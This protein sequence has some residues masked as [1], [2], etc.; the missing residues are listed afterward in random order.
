MEKDNELLEIISE[1]NQVLEK[2]DYRKSRYISDVSWFKECAKMIEKN[3][4]RVAIMGITSSGK[5]TLVNAILGENI[6]PV[7]I[8]PS[9]S[10]IIT[11]SKGEKRQATVYFHHKECEILSGE[12]LNP[13][14]IRYFADESVNPDN[15]LKV[16]QIDITVPDFLLGDNI[17]IIDSPGLDAC[18]L[19]MH[20]K[21]TLEILLPT[22]D[23]CVFLTTVKSNSDAVNLEKLKTVHEKGKQIIMVQNMID[24]VESKIGKNGIIEED[25]PT[26]LKKHKK[27]AERLLSLGTDNTDEF[28]VIQISALNGFKG[29]VN[30]DENLYNESNLSSF[31][32]GIE[33]CIDK[34]MPDI[35]IAR[36]ISIKK[37]ID[38]I[39]TTDRG[40]ISG[41]EVQH[42]KSL[43]KV[44]A[45]HIDDLVLDFTNARDKIAAKIKLI[46][47]VVEN[48]IKSINSGNESDP[49]GYLSII[50]LINTQNEKLENRILGIV[51]RCEENK[52]EIYRRLNLDVRFSYSIPSMITGTIDVKHKYEERKRK[53]EKKGVF[54]LGKRVL[55]QMF[56]KTWGYDEV[57]Y[58]KEIV[59]KDATIAMVEE[60][61]YQ[62][63][64]KYLDILWEWSNQY[65]KS[66]NLFYS[67]VGKRT[68]EYESKKE[69]KIQ[70]NDITDVIRSL[71]YMSNKLS[72]RRLKRKDE[73][74]Y[75][76]L[77]K[78]GLEDFEFVDGTD[79]SSEE[80]ISDK[81]EAKKY[82][83]MNL[84]E[85]ENSHEKHS[86]YEISNIQYN[87]YKLSNELLERNYLLV[88][89]YI[90]KKSICT[91]SGN[92]KT[93]F[94]TY[95]IDFCVSFI[96]RIC[97]IYLNENQCVELKKNGI[98][99]QDEIVIIYELAENNL[100]AYAAFEKLK[101]YNN[102]LFIIFNGIQIGN[103]QKQILESRMIREFMTNNNV[104]INLVVDSSREFINAD[105][106]KELLV[107]VFNLK[108]HLRNK[109]ISSKQGYILINSRNPI[110]NMALIEAQERETLIL[111][112]YLNLKENLFRNAFSRSTQER[113]V[114]EEILDY[115]LD[116]FI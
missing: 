104:F 93:I 49:D 86:N 46:D 99:E 82:I 28:E 75:E 26:I 18:N 41:S 69:Q 27:R 66:L 11:C 114:I 14:K 33:N 6:L 30:K 8:K 2:D 98:Y 40:I 96:S 115:F 103:S 57:E 90:N 54:N 45:T 22:I 19:E 38:Q 31:V 107:E 62:N 113:K 111:S 17:H 108:T 73:K 71:K 34:V 67:E 35:D 21:L 60:V 50:D 95:D 61:C 55:S 1:I 43:K 110:Y 102:N 74:R 16:A 36:E 44:T 76:E 56:D 109:F 3:I 84:N 20:E 63:R 80:V 77:K 53:V 25:K 64:K 101:T 106:I 105:N 59:D 9:S 85:N 10:I 52:A 65:A 42:I 70:I 94:W 100:N 89:D 15:K 32:K 39:I 12:D 29:R 72:R 7:A 91:L 92:C 81:E 5:S 88:G 13:E 48:T 112:E 97:G 4:I 24:S 79:I 68:E 78:L 23:I 116:K 37:R 51:K 83:S 58:D 47:K 87:V